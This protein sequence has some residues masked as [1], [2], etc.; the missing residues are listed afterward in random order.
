MMSSDPF[1]DEVFVK[2]FNR[3]RHEEDSVNACVDEPAIVARFKLLAPHNAVELGCGTGGLT[4]VL[5]HHCQS[6]SSV[7]QSPAMIDMARAQ[8]AATN[9]DFICSSFEKFVPCMEADVVVSGMAMHLVA[10]LSEL[11]NAI[12]SWLKP[13]GAF[14]FSQRHPIRTAN[15]LGADPS[16]GNPS[17]KV[18]SYFDVGERTY[19][20]LGYDVSYHHRTL[21]EIVA[22]VVGVGFELREIAEPLPVDHHHTDRGAE[23]HSS[24]AVLLIV[25]KKPDHG[26]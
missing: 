21:S 6:L 2:R 12:Y 7:D 23:N 26:V 10:D 19:N 3:R 17:W 24:P 16:T 18:S 22:S 25:C 1:R 20:W 5:A 15:P 4:A 13:G 8:V 9:V 11:C 14:I